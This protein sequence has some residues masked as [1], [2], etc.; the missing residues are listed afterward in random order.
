MDSK[1]HQKCLG[2]LVKGKN[3]KFNFA[4][5]ALTVFNLYHSHVASGT[6][7]GTLNYWTSATRA[8]CSAGSKFTWCSSKTVVQDFVEWDQGQPD[9]AGG[10]QLCAHLRVNFKDGTTTL[11]DRNCTDYYPIAC[12]V[13]TI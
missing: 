1:E 11:T 7:L 13:S 12:Q 4:K 5:R 6:W 9:N 8:G 10:N 3:L 2:D